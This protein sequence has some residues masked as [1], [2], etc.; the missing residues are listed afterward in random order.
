MNGKCES[1]PPSSNNNNNTSST[2]VL[3]D[4]FGNL[5][6]IEANVEFD[7]GVLAEVEVGKLG[8]EDVYTVFNTSY[9]GP[10]ACLMFDEGAK[11]L[12]AVTTR[13]ASPSSATKGEGGALG[14]SA[15]AG[16]GRGRVE[17]AVG[18]LLGVGV[19]FVSL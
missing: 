2:T 19:W 10:T 6:H 4:V 8:A 3:E 18:M 16:R 11:T 7:V 13:S 9:A 5:T 14:T 1:L 15:A 12:G 17:V